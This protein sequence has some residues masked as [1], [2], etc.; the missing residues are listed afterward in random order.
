MST[1]DPEMSATSVTD[2]HSA[3]SP[4]LA[5]VTAS[6]LG[7]VTIIAFETMAVTTAM[8]A[9]ALSLAAGPSYGL[10]FSLMFTGQL[11]GI[12]VAG[13]W[14]GARGPM[15][16]L[17]T[18]LGVFAAGSVVAGVAPSFLVFLAGRLVAGLGG[19]LAFVS[20]YVVIG[21]AYPAPLQ[22]QVFGWVAAAWVVPSIV[23]PLVAAALTS[24]WGWRSVFLLI[25]AMGVPA[26]VGLR[27][28]GPLLARGATCAATPE[29]VTSGV[30][31][32][33]GTGSAARTVRHGLGMACGALIFQAGTT[34][35]GLPPGM[36]PIA[37]VL[38]MILLAWCV[39]PLMPP[40]TFRLR[41]GE[42]SVMVARFTYMASFNAAIAFVALM[43]VENHGLSLV[44]SGSIVALAS[45]GWAAGSFIQ[46]RAVF[47]G[48]GADLIRMGSVVLSVSAVGL[49][50]ADV[51]AGPP[52]VV[53]VALTG[54]GVAM[55]MGVTSTSVVALAL[56]PP[57]EHASASASLQ[58]A[59]VLGSVTGVAMATVGYAAALSAHH[60]VTEAFIAVWSVTVVMALATLPAAWRIGPASVVK[61]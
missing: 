10:S 8:P 59:D 9:V 31:S 6:L 16:T 44:M 18:G 52:W 11:A 60:P 27:R 15:P 7:L 5:T 55:G 40:G 35:H 29:V 23:G 48:R 1:T 14:A 39:P 43:L 33:P 50:V 58:V 49:W 21:S 53:A 57:Q 20:L 26:A 28:A 3:F 41:S 24:G 34:I 13:V 36:G 2:A 56:A 45:L 4:G 19:G 42:P 51:L 12:V 46:G 47:V 38:G 54:I 32:G 37:A 22:P 30:D 61:D 25:P 17:W